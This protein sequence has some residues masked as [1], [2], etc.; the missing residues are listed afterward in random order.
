MFEA[1]R[2]T[3]Q[4]ERTAE[5]GQWVS[6]VMAEK[7][8]RGEWRVVGAI[9]PDLVSAM[10]AHGVMPQTAELVVRDE[11]VLHTFRDAK[12]V[13]LAED[14]YR[15]LPDQVTAPAAVVL[16]KTVVGSPALLYVFDLPD[17]RAKLVL[18]LDYTVARRNAEGKKERVSVNIFRAGRLVDPQDLD[19]PGY[20]WLQGK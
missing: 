10:A 6:K 13:Q 3:L 2:P 1:M 9:A 5:F 20:V 14:W 7:R 15:G 12:R 11:D 8:P 19:Q 17:Q 18:N 4:R 16:D